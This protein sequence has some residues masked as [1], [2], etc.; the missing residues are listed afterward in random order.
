MSHKF[1][2]F[3]IKSSYG[4]KPHVRDN[5]KEL[6]DYSI[7][8]LTEN[9]STTLEHAFQSVYAFDYRL[10]EYVNEHQSIRDLNIPHYAPVIWFDIDNDSSLTDAKKQTV[11]LIDYMEGQFGLQNDNIAVFFSGSKGFHVAIPS[12]FIDMEPSSKVH[13]YV[14]NFC[15]LVGKSADINMDDTIYT[16]NHIIRLSNTKNEK[17]GLYKIPLTCEELRTYQVNQ[18]K[19]I[20]ENWRAGTPPSAPNHHDAAQTLWIKAM[21]LVESGIKPQ[22]SLIDTQ[23]VAMS[24]DVSDTCESVPSGCGHCSPSEA[25]R[26]CTAYVD[27]MESSIQGKEGS[28]DMFAVVCRAYWDFG[29]DGHE[30]RQVIDKYNQRACPPWTDNEIEHKVKDVRE[31]CNKDK[32][33]GW[34]L[35]ESPTAF[36]NTVSASAVKPSDFILFDNA[37]FLDNAINAFKECKKPEMFLLGYE[38]GYDKTFDGIEIRPNNII[39]IG[40]IPG[41]GKTAFLTQMVSNLLLFNKSLTVVNANIEM[42]RDV[43]FNRE[44]CR[45]GKIPQSVIKNPTQENIEKYKENLDTALTLMKNTLFSQRHGFVDFSHQRVTME[46]IF[47]GAEKAGARIVILDYLQ[48]IPLRNSTANLYSDIGERITLCRRFA[49]KGNVVIVVTALARN[50]QRG[51]AYQDIGLGSG[52]GSSEIEYSADLY[53]ILRAKTHYDKQEKKEVTDDH[54]VIFECIKN[55]H[56][57]LYSLSYD[58]DKN[59]MKF[60]LLVNWPEFTKNATPNIA[61]SNV[62]DHCDENIDPILSF[63]QNFHQE[64][65][66]YE[67]TP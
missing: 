11:S 5:Y 1:S 45:L 27:K 36:Q 7:K 59:F 67:E 6:F 2:S 50:N 37:S 52:S 31:T 48:K 47:D 49:E 44:L 65:L 58:F 21:E 15:T 10:S 3:F 40:G 18:I 42:G 56:G 54:C 57:D 64:F 53:G 17:S 4:D 63:D 26:R 62:P 43:F 20:A 51:K 32:P 35:G 24:D 61:R 14:K 34:L 9:N 12:T 39:T 19:E 16:A 8:E 66:D 23:P 55:R 60:A 33:R 46:D 13:T 25:V 28:M 22:K 29:L 41:V 38:D 30:L